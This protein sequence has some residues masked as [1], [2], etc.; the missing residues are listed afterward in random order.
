MENEE[1]H[2]RHPYIKNTFITKLSRIDNS[3]KVMNILRKCKNRNNWILPKK[4]NLELFP[5]HKNRFFVDGFKTEVQQRNKV[6]LNP[7]TKINYNKIRLLTT[8]RIRKQLNEYKKY[9][10]EEADN[11]NLNHKFE[12]MISGKKMDTKPNYDFRKE[13]YKKIFVRSRV[14]TQTIQ[15][16]NKT[17]KFNSSPIFFGKNDYVKRKRCH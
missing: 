2:R 10:D 6:E 11:I 13:S 8:T 16:K 4:I 9:L 17:N 5:N 15:S 1:F 7:E 14:N 12:H 3:S